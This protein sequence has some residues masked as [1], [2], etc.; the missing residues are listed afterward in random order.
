MHDDSLKYDDYDDSGMPIYDQPDFY[1]L[2]PATPVI[3]TPR[4]THDDLHM[5]VLSSDPSRRFPPDVI[6][7][8]FDG[9]DNIADRDKCI[10]R[11]TDIDADVFAHHVYRLTDSNGFIVTTKLRTRLIGESN[12]DKAMYA[13]LL[14]L[15][16]VQHAMMSI[17]LPGNIIQS[18]HIDGTP[19]DPY[20]DFPPF[21][22]Q[23]VYSNDRSGSFPSGQDEDFFARAFIPNDYNEP[24]YRPPAIE[25]FGQELAPVGSLVAIVA[26]PGVGKSSTVEMS[27]E[28]VI[29]GEPRLGLK[30]GS[31]TKIAILDGEMTDQEVYKAYKRIKRR[32]NG[33]P[34]YPIIFGTLGY[35]I[36]ERRKFAEFLIKDLEYNLIIFDGGTDLIHDPND[37]KETDEV[38]NQWLRPMLNHHGA[39]AIM[40]IHDNPDKTGMR[41]EK[42]RGH[43]GAEVLRR[44]TGILN[45][46][47]D[48]KTGVRTLSTGGSYGKFRHG[49]PNQSAYFMWDENSKMMA[50]IGEPPREE[51]QV[52]ANLPDIREIEH[53]L[54]SIFKGFTTGMLRSQITDKIQAV[55]GKDYTVSRRKSEQILTLMMSEQLIHTQGK[56]GTKAY[57]FHFGRPTNEDE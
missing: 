4:P 53:K 31:Y 18:A 19:Y 41:S 51:K 3:L 29:T 39:T 33:S 40:T 42:P 12:H 21:D 13:E 8:L 54:P 2:Y 37:L 23:P 10:K 57:K 17:A 22:S 43:F 1:D 35:S 24:E 44:S 30:F 16:W 38:I 9:F 48:R 20:R 32:I 26:S 25:W 6:P 36:P 11:I 5:R 34:P 50:E 28:S 15:H 55:F 14:R 47:H 52:K 45:I 27:A 49:N 7:I 46:I 56:E